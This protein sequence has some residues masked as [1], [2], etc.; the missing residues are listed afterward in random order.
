[1]NV[2]LGRWAQEE[3]QRD[4]D[5][6]RGASEELGEEVGR[7]TEKK[8]GRRG[9]HEVEIM[10]NLEVHRYQRPNAKRGNRATDVR[11]A[12]AAH[13]AV[14]GDAVEGDPPATHSHPHEYT[15]AEEAPNPHSHQ[16]PS[17]HNPS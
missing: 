9:V 16:T 1:M 8:E 13:T 11:N 10:Y 14:A 2:E 12:A 15:P 5:K 4:S 7:G 17:L 6:N 3:S